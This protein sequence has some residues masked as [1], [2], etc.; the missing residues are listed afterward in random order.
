MYSDGR[1]VRVLNAVRYRLSLEFLPRLIKA[2]PQR[3][4]QI[5]GDE[6]RNFVTL[7]ER[8][9]AGGLLRYAVFF[10]VKKDSRRKRRLVLQVQSAYSLDVLTK[11]QRSAGK[12]RFATLLRA[13]YQGRKV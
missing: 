3:T 5:A 6:H 13:A 11:R 9:E 12:V 1:E 8:S 7:E 2:L 10:D 4:I